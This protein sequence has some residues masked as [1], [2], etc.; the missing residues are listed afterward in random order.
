MDPDGQTGLL[1]NV[2]PA[3][4][5]V[6]TICTFSQT[7][8][9]ALHSTTEFFVFQ[10]RPEFPGQ[11]VVFNKTIAGRR[12]T[13]LLNLSLSFC[14]ILSPRKP[15][16]GFPALYSSFNADIRR[17]TSCEQKI[18]LPLFLFFC[19]QANP[20]DGQWRQCRQ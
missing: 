10:R 14:Q 12:R 1:L 16:P 11:K 19:L 3:R 6:K 15:L 5:S 17:M 2:K 20:Q 18:S 8:S 13:L 4:M 9:L 7:F